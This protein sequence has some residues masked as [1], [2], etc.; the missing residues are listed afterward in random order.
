M[1]LVFVTCFLFL[2]TVGGWAQGSPA[3][4]VLRGRVTLKESGEAIKDAV[5]TVAQ[6]RR[7]TSTDLGGNYEFAGV[8]AGK[9]DVIAHIDRVADVVK[10][11]DTTNGTTTVDFELALISINEQV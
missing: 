8:P 4:I 1:K 11:V 6:L 7:S 5:V 3:P 9:Y 10:T 2:S